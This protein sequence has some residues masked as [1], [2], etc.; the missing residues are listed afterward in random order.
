MTI[1]SQSSFRQLFAGL[2]AV[3]ARVDAAGVVEHLGCV[4]AVCDQFG[5]RSLDVGD[6]QVQ[7]LGRA[8]R[9]RGDVLD[10]R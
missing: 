2:L 10:R 7:A 5:A 8:G 9:G 3:R 4:D 6:D 1:T